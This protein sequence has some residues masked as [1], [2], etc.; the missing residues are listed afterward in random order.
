[1]SVK[2]AIIGGSGF[3]GTRLGK[4]LEKRN[5]LEFIILD[6]EPSATFPDHY[7]H[8][9]VREI[10]S[11]REGLKG[12]DLII[13]L[14]AEHKDNV[15][16][17]EL[18]YEVNVEGQKNICEVAEELDIKRHIFTSSVAIYGFVECDTDESGT[19]NPFNDYGRSKL[20]A[21]EILDD[22]YVEGRQSTIIRP[23]VIFGEGNRGNVYNLLR[24]IASGKFMMI[25]NGE[26]KKSMAYVE[27]IAAFIEYM[28]DHG[29]ERQI[30]NYADKP[31]FT[32]NELCTAVFEALGRKKKPLR[33]PYFIGLVGGMTF[34]ILSRILGREFPISAIR[35]KKFCA[36]TQF[37]SKSINETGF[38]PPADLRKAILATVKSE[39]LS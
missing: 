11:L 10:P 9:D 33:L 31:D 28:I 19:F 30:F 15:L 17:I 1:M 32:M 36:T 26:N 18:Y 38:I 25:G 8:C 13:N 20:Q 39:F 2:I 5:D 16:P 6:K 21:E 35:V 3:I 34:D 22:W 7:K 29:K 37:S 23:T 24:Q 14:A 27:N 12:C 4:R